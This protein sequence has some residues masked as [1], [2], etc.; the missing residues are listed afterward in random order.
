MMPIF[1]SHTVSAFIAKKA[2]LWHSFFVKSTMPDFYNFKPELEPDQRSDIKL[3]ARPFFYEAADANKEKLVIL[4]HGYSSSPYDFQELGRFLAQHNINARGVLLAG[5]GGDFEHFA[6]ADYRDWWWSVRR[7]VD[8]Y[9][10][11]YKNI[12]LIGYSFGSNL[13]LD[14]AARYPSKLAGVICLGTSVY[15]RNYK[16]IKLLYLFLSLFRDRVNK[17]PMPKSQKT[18]Y[19]R[20]GGHV[21]LPMKSLGSF[22]QFINQISRRQIEQVTVPILLVH[23]RD[24][25]ISSPRSSEMIFERISSSNKEL[26]ILNEYEHNPLHSGNRDLIF[27]K[28]LTFLTSP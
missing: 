17:R 28:V 6:Q 14:L 25:L 16:K 7:E 8:S 2:N 5:H 21:T 3:N 15:L 19:E 12:F 10:Q 23:S 11:D 9:G 18:L 24:D 4:V 1:N 27:D 22:L 20:D 13:A 26:F